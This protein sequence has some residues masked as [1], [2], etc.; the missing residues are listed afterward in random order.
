MRDKE[1]GRTA[2]YYAIRYNA[3]DGVVDMLLGFMDRVDIL[4]CDRDGMSVLGLVWDKWVVSYEGKRIMAH[5]IKIFDQWNDAMKEASNDEE[6]EN[7][8]KKIVTQSSEI[9]EGLKGKLKDSWEKV[10]LILR[11]A[12]RFDLNEK[13]NNA[14]DA[15]TSG[16]NNSESLSVRKWRILHAISAIQCHPSLFLMASILHPEQARELDRFDL[17]RGD[18]QTLKG[19]SGSTSASASA[20]ASASTSNLASHQIQTALHFA[21]KSPTCGSESKVVL[22]RLLLFYP[23]AVKMKNPGDESLP[24][25]YLCENESKQHWV[26]DGIR[27]VYDSYPEAV[28]ITDVDGRTPLHRAATLHESS[29]F[30]NPPP[31]P[32]IM[33]TPTRITSSS[34]SYSSGDATNT[35]ASSSVRTG[36]SNFI[37]SVEDPVGSIIQNI[38]SSHPEVASIPDVSGKVLLHYI[39]ECAESW[40]QNVQAIYDAYPEALSR[41]ESVTRGLPLH[42]VA[43]NLD[44]KTRLLQKIVEY[45]PRAASL[46]NGDGRLPLHLACE[47]GKTWYS[48]L[49]DIYNAY[50]NAVNV[51]EEGGLRW[52]PLHFV[53]SSPYS[54]VETI[55]RILG[56]GPD[57][58][59][60]VDQLGRTPFH[61]A[62]ESGKEWEEGGLQSL[63]QANPEAIDVPD[64][65]GKIPLVT[66][67]LGYCSD[68]CVPDGNEFDASE[69]STS[70][71]SVPFTDNSNNLLDDGQCTGEG[72]CDVIDSTH[73]SQVNVVFHL[74]RAAPHVLAPMD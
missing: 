26:H 27:D 70:T 57:V 38:L 48:G 1:K 10:N 11:G 40:D 66:A 14:E 12:F 29:I 37:T 24:L 65:E 64:I 25:H 16:A 46:V 49:E 41:R 60:V 56:L 34:R 47:T 2:L 69:N 53:V 17:L 71:D 72:E 13:S 28:T 3:P 39:A 20:S 44:A 4:D 73:V 74:L 55:E 33:S 7:A 42:L 6:R 43:S 36:N 23:E 15:G 59:H 35:N 19:I 45:H 63:F 67:L 21:A 62:V 54:S 31:P 32:S 5:Y 18:Q 58:A 30:F 50:T 22:K 52:T 8:W 68:Q 51:A 9:R 61:L